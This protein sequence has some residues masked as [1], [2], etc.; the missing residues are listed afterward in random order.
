MDNIGF[1]RCIVVKDK[2]QNRDAQINH[3]FIGH[4]QTDN[5]SFQ[6]LAEIIYTVKT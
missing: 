2:Q 5:S 1:Q 6:I 3:I 4:I